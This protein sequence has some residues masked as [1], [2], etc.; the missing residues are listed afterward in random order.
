MH[1]LVIYKNEQISYLH[2]A[3][4]SELAE[5]WGSKHTELKFTVTIEK[6]LFHMRFV[7]P[8]STGS[9]IKYSENNMSYVQSVVSF[10]TFSKVW[11]VV[12]GKATDKVA[13]KVL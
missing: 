10:P 12:S 2:S 6:S 3:I 11:C 7:E 1:L 13:D 9:F 5:G 8:L 4:K